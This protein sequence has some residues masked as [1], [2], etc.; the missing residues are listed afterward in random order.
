[1]RP[2]IQLLAVD[3]LGKIERVIAVHKRL[4]LDKTPKT[5]DAY[6][7]LTVHEPS[8]AL[9]LADG[10]PAGMEWKGLIEYRMPDNP[11]PAL[12]RA[13]GVDVGKNG[14]GSTYLLPT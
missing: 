9:E 2:I 3:M 5:H 11:D 1:M 13:T 12:L 4:S 8:C 7:N 14:Y 6:V 10:E